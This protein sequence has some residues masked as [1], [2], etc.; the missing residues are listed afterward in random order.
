MEVQ[1]HL[2]SPVRLFTAGQAGDRR[3]IATLVENAA[4]GRW[5]PEGIKRARISDQCSSNNNITVYNSTTPGFGE[6]RKFCDIMICACTVGLSF[7]K[8]QVG[9]FY[10]LVLAGSMFN[11]IPMLVLFTIFSRFYVQGSTYDGVKG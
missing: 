8:G 7:R 10:N 4:L 6:C 5:A 1:G 9:T 2:W 3:A 11:T